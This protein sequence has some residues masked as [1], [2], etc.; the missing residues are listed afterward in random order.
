MR[1]ALLEAKFERDRSEP[2]SPWVCRSR[3]GGQVCS[4]KTAWMRGVKL[5]GREG[6]RFHELRGVEET[7][8][9]EAGVPEQRV[10]QIAG[11]KSSRMVQRYCKTSPELLREVAGIMD[12][13]FVKPVDSGVVQWFRQQNPAT[14]HDGNAVSD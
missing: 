9:L 3:M 1:T 5:I 7:N 4:Y 6:L 14:A 13:R 10:M 11:H 8:L 12:G 2:D